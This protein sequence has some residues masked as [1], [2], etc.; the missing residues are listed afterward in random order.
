MKRAYIE[1]YGCQMNISDSELMHGILAEQGFST[2]DKPED[3]DVILVNTCAIRDHAE[4]RVIGRV[5][6]LQQIRRDN[7]DVV[8]GVTGC[9]AQRMGESLLGRA[10]GVDMVMG[11]D[12]YRQLSD[13]LAEVVARRGPAGRL[14]M[15]QSAPA[16][17]ARGLAVLGFDPH[18][19]YEG[20]AAKRISAVSAWVP[21][22]RGCNYRCTYC[23]V[24]YVRGDEK[25]RD[26]QAILDE[27]RALAADGVPEVT[28]LGQT[29]N[30]Y[31]HGGW[32][33]PRLLREV[34]HVDGIRRV[35]FT[36]PHP[37]DFT[38]ELVEAMAEEPRVCKQLHLP[39]QSGHNRTL[40]RM[41]RRYTVE[42]YLEKIEWV[43]AAMP[44]ISLSTDVIVGFP[45]ETDEE[46]EATLQLMRTVRYDDAFLYK[47]SLRDGTPATRLPA[48]QFVPDEIGSARL[49]RLIET[50]RAI[51]AEIYQSEVG[52]TEEVLV[53]KEGKRGGLQGRTGGNKVVTFE[54][55]VGLIGHFVD[56]ELT[57][58]S[59]STFVGEMAGALAAA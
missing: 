22:Q 30:S 14:P 55:P 56:V 15:S 10:G 32:N 31:E 39:V 9:M 47:Y 26:P 45:G 51:Q 23:I 50:H 5:G 35:R 42:E 59:G 27:V 24:P 4:Q 57:G 41:L 49:Q 20:V 13:K 40:K 6:Q 54:G 1:T 33:F 16:I 11:P 58:T 8:I 46:Y 34:A 53:E 43:R 17:A 19:N 18:E 52:R 37:N 29:V 3:A 2:T 38:R 36:S 25:N 21:I 12:A 28:L 7:P 48:D 44:G